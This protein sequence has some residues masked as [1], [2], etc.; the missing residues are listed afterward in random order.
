MG[1]ATSYKQND[2]SSMLSVKGETQFAYKIESLY[3]KYQ[4]ENTHEKD[5]YSY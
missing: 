4:H 3:Y 2:E 5:P 1:L